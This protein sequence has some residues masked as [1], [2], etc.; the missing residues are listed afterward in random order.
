[1]THRGLR[2]TKVQPGPS[3][4][5]EFRSAWIPSLRISA[6]RFNGFG[7]DVD[8]AGYSAELDTHDQTLRVTVRADAARYQPGGTAHLAIQTRDAS[9]APVSASVIVRVI[10]EKLYAIGA[11]QDVD[12]LGDLY[13]P[14]SDGI[15]WSGWSHRIPE[16]GGDGGD[17]T[18]GGG[19]ERT[20]FRDWLLF[21]QV[22]TGS[23]GRASVD[24]PLS[25][26]LTSWRA[27]A[28]GVDAK[29]DAGSGIANLRVGLPFFAD[30]ILGPTYLV[31]ET[32][33]LRMRGFGSG[34]GAS[35]QVTFQVSAPSLGL[36]PQTVTA[37]AFQAASVALPAL[38]A[39]THEIHIA[40]SIGSGSARLQDALVRTIKVI[41][42]RSMATRTST[43]PLTA[44][45]EIQG[46][47][48][49]LTTMVL[50]DAGRGR[51]LPVLLGLADSAHD[52]GRLDETLAGAVA[53]T[54]LT[55]AFKMPA[56]D[57]SV[58]NLDLGP[59][60]RDQGLGLFPYASADLELSVFA[61]L[62]DD[63]AVSRQDLEQYFGNVKG[64]TAETPERQRIALVGLAAI[65]DQVGSEIR[66]AAAD[67]SLT[68]IDRAWLAVGALATGDESLA[69]DIERGILAADGQRLGPWVRVWTGDTESSATT[70]ALLDMVA[71][72]IGDPLAADL[73]AYIGANPPKDTLVD[74]QRAIA[75]RDWAAR[76]PGQDAVAALTV[77]GVT[78]QVA[79]KPLEPGWVVLTPAQLASAI[80]APVSGS[81]VVTTT[82]ETP[83]AVAGLKP[84]GVDRF[85]RTVKPADAIGLTDAVIVQYQVFFTSDASRECWRLT[86]QVPSGLA[87]IAH[88]TPLG[89]G[90]PYPPGIGPFD[91]T[92]QRVDFCVDPD[93]TMP[94]YRYVARVVSPGT[95]DWEPA[96]LQSSVVPEWGRTIPATEVT[97]ANR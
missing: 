20:D 69:T 19:D 77:D 33:I 55:D 51:V 89:E 93:D 10:D 25:D 82:W 88:P 26:D 95:F 67:T 97:I 72:G 22:T 21:R 40:A 6:V 78:R 62:S 68:A 5:T 46:G 8:T 27:L 45:F 56:S 48:D 37:K 24:V 43:A 64:D 1:M 63:P 59:Y 75:A 14:V 9:G 12:L 53:Q 15:L 7:Y 61:A 17:T 96:V 57:V 91:I 73:D 36:A 70:T 71:A 39:G 92:G 87:P 54:V 34:L 80:L 86:D 18:G 3:F 30:A 83:G 35:D 90:D 42:T 81:I 44:G 58:E 31:G 29:L 85:V 2:T 41:P 38:P 32:P 60:E 94:T 49:G 13:A 4:T 52:T 84:T 11:A 16:Q 47:T 28:S 66:E 74:L 23:D 65:G 76:T 79:V 50:G